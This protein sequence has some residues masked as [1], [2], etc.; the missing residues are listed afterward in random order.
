MALSSK[1]ALPV[2]PNS[3]VRVQGGGGGT[4]I[5]PNGFEPLARVRLIMYLTGENALRE[6][7]G[8]P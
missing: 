8:A 7:L 2:Y 5:F 6:Y 1:V 4:D 3:E